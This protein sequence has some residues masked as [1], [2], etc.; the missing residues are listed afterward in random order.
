MARGLLTPDEAGERMAVAF[1][2]ETAGVIGPVTA[3]QVAA[4][5]SGS[6]FSHPGGRWVRWVSVPTRAAPD[7]GGRWSWIVARVI[8]RQHLSGD[9]SDDEIG[10]ST[11]VSTFDQDAVKRGKV[12]RDIAGRG[13]DSPFGGQV[14]YSRDTPDRWIRRYR[15]GGFDTLSELLYAPTRVALVSGISQTREC[16]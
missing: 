6:G 4:A 10:V 8:A 13:H 12:V 5:S 16:N 7:V 14:R 1:A 11:V 9:P 15:A 3:W 2:A